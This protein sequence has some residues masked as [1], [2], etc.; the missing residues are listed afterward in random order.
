MHM[1]NEKKKLLSG[2]VSI[3]LEKLSYKKCNMTPSFMK[4]EETGKQEF[5]FVFWASQYY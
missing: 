4:T 3:K 2:T 1:S 5:N